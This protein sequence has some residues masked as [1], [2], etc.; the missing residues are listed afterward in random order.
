MATLPLLKFVK[1]QL[2]VRSIHKNIA[3]ERTIVDKLNLVIEPVTQKSLN[4]LGSLQVV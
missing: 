1:K 4:S 3:F 2:F